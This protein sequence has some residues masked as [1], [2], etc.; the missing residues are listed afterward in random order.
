MFITN[1]CNLETASLAQQYI[2]NRNS[3][4]FKQNLVKKIANSF[5]CTNMYAFCMRVRTELEVNMTIFDYFHCC[6]SLGKENRKIGRD[7]S[8]YL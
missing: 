6:R 2:F 4:I 5:F 8:G 3:N 1:L 7:I